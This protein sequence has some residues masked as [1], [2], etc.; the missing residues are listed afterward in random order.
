[1]PAGHAEALPYVMT[2]GF[3]FCFR[4]LQQPL[5]LLRFEAVPCMMAP[6]RFSAHQELAKEDQ[7]LRADGPVPVQ[8]GVRI[9]YYC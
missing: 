5:F 8:V 4:I 9:P 6:S 7:I 3:A 1:M 2:K